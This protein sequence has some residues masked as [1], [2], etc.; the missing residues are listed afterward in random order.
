MGK[1]DGDILQMVGASEMLDHMVRTI[2]R[3]FHSNRLEGHLG[4]SPANG[5]GV[6]R[7]SSQTRNP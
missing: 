1:S 2:W 4:Y 5:T 3:R 7:G 6:E